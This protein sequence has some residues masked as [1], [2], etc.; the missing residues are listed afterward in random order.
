MAE[1]VEVSDN[2]HSIITRRN[3]ARDAELDKEIE[4]LERQ[5]LSPTNEDNEQ[6]DL[7]ETVTPKA[8]PTVPKP[9]QVE[10]VEDDNALS[11]EEKNFKKR[12]GDLRRH[13]QKKEQEFQAQIDE[14]KKKL[15][16]APSQM[17]TNEEEIKKW[18]E[19][20]PKAAAIVKALAGEEVS[21][22]SKEISTK[23][24][25]LEKDQEEVSREKALQK[26][27]NKHNDFDDL[28]EDDAFH[29]WIGTKPDFI[30]TAVYDGG[31]D[32]V[33]EV[34]DLYKQHMAKPDTGKNAAL[35]VKTNRNADL[36]DMTSSQWSESKVHK[37]S[38]AEYEKHEDAIQEAMASGKFIYDLS[39]GAR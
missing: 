17:P 4:E 23:L 8:K 20:N 27:R 34:L 18:A 33:I 7:E 2:A 29:N 14:L 13:S 22:S 11:A 35:K 36:G 5:N 37:M 1:K 26:I 28:V 9:E 21:R 3:D 25:R 30:Q 12:Y 39:G 24:E 19:N 15:E 32:E 31:P 38:D 10:V 16:S 6:V